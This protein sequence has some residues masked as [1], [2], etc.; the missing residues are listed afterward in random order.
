MGEKRNFWFRGMLEIRLTIQQLEDLLSAPQN[1]SF[2][3][4]EERSIRYIHNTLRG[5]WWTERFTDSWRRVGAQ[6]CFERKLRT[7]RPEGRFA[8]FVTV[9]NFFPRIRFGFSTRLGDPGNQLLAKH[10]LSL[11]ALDLSLDLQIH[12][13]GT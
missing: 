4:Y 9:T 7:I 12:D 1:C 13:S 3:I 11:F 8:G 2:C 6:R 10:T 5:G